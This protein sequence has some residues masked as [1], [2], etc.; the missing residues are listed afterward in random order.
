[1][2]SYKA[3][4]I[5]LFL[6]IIG[7]ATFLFIKYHGKNS[8]V[9][10]ITNESTSYPGKAPAG[11]YIYKPGEV[12]VLTPMVKYQLSNGTIITVYKRNP[13]K[14]ILHPSP[15]LDIS[16]PE[17]LRVF[18]VSISGGDER[19]FELA[20]TL[21]I[22][23]SRLFYNNITKTYIFYNETHLFE[24][25][26]EKGYLRLKLRSAPTAAG[27]FPPSDV[28]M[29]KAIEFLRSRG[30]LYMSDYTV[31]VGDYLV[32]GDKVLLKAVVLEAKLDGI[33]VE[34]LGLAVVFDSNGKV[35][36]VEGVI[37][38]GIEVVGEF[39]VKSF[40]E[41]LKELKAK[42]ADGAPMTDWYISWLAFTELRI[43]NATIEYR[44][45]PDGYIVPVYVLRGEYRLDYDVIH[46]SG[47][48]ECIIV[49]IQAEQRT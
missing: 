16:V 21:G 42:I 35:V 1:M 6:V 25:N 44:L 40:S 31:R 24:Y 11:F 7:S 17:R 34:N 5:I 33:V 29:A 46:D 28:L 19:A 4:I 12:E 9:V 14:F 30:L 43:T 13:F 22:D 10:S 36:G 45:T 48:L 18:K 26:A 15:G 47:T 27:E 8:M 49:A 39:G 41:V 38:A 37:P 2:K 32:S 20:S 23:T 3:L